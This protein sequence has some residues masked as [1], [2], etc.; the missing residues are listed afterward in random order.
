MYL[1]ALPCVEVLN[2]F[3]FVHHSPNLD[4]GLLHHEIEDAEQIHHGE[5]GEEEEEGR[6]LDVTL[7]EDDKDQNVAE[8]AECTDTREKDSLQDGLHHPGVHTV[9]GR[10]V[11]ISGH[12]FWTY[13]NIF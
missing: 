8:D 6:G 10:G 5:D 11:N 1:T 13:V 4:K 3:V 7:S 2:P 12:F 9:A